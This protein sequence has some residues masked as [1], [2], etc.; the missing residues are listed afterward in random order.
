MAN[1]KTSPLGSWRIGA[2]DNTAI[3]VLEGLQKYKDNQVTYIKGADLTVGRTEFV[4]ETKINETEKSSFNEAIENAKN[5]DIVVMVLGEHG[6]QTGEGRSRTDLGFPGVQQELLEA[7]FKANPY[8]ILV[9]NNGRPFAIPWADEN[10]PAIIEAWH[11]G[12]K[13]GNA[14]ANVLYGDYNPSAKL[15]M[16]FPRNVGQVPIYYNHNNTGRPTMNEPKIVFYIRD[17]FASTT[18][19]VKEL[20]GFEMID[21]QPNETKIVKFIINEKTIEFYSANNKW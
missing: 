11:L 10:I 17:L 12:R 18:R 20:K 14:I 9:L 2:D 4:W 13:S 6:L 1:D 7:V 8:I 15:P 19:P 16:T 21:L 5:A 3:L